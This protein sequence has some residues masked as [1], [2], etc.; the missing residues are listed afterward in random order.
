MYDSSGGR[1]SYPTLILNKL[2]GI[3]LRD[4]SFQDQKFLGIIKK[5]GN[6]VAQ[7]HNLKIEHTGFGLIDV[8]RSL[9]KGKL[10][11]SFLR[12]E[13][14]IFMNLEKHLDICYEQ[15]IIN[16]E[17]KSWVLGFFQNHQSDVA[18]RSEHCLLHGDLGSHNIF[19]KL[20]DDGYSRYY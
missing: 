6:K 11:G 2:K 4:I 15:K 19:V 12:W 17:E 13:E 16:L 20:S 3:C 5:L 7:Y 1:L 18:N 14:Y 8:T 10:C 9:E